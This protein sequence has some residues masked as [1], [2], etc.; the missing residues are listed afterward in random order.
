MITWPSQHRNLAAIVGVVLVAFVV[1]YVLLI[2]PK[3][4]EVARTRTEMETLQTKLVQKGWPLDSSRL[5]KL[6]EEKSKELVRFVKLSDEVL[7]D[8]T[9][10]FDPKITSLFE[11]ADNFRNNVSRL[12]YKEEFIQAEQHFRD[13]GVIFGE[14]VLKLSENSDSPYTYQLVLQLWTLRGLTDLALKYGL[15]PAV[16]PRV[17]TEGEAGAG[18][19]PIAKLTVLPMRAYVSQPNEKEPYLLEF[20]VRMVL[21]GRLENLCNFLRALH[22]PYSLVVP[23]GAKP[24]DLPEH[25]FFPVSRLEVHKAMPSWGQP[26]ADQI[27]ADIQCSSFYRLRASVPKAVENKVMILPAGG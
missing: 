24:A 9:R 23:P 13:Q 14:E 21:V 4:Q 27:E 8:A 6:K 16:D 2:R 18:S 19:A 15:K 7:Q 3:Q 10:M 5:D 26:P 12:D 25:N 1:A 20:P 17:R 22:G 11:N